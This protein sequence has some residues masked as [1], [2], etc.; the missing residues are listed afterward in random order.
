[1]I[2]TAG[3]TSCVIPHPG[4]SPAVLKDQI[5]A[6]APEFLR[7][8]YTEGFLITCVKNKDRVILLKSN[9]KVPIRILSQ[10]LVSENGKH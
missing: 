3:I 2:P 7:Y 6:K 4:D 5:L 8:A 10:P 1:M 9:Q